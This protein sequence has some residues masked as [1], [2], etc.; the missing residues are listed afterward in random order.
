M[1]FMIQHGYGKGDKLTFVAGEAELGAVI[2]SPTDEDPTSLRATVEGLRS[3]GVRSLLDPQ[4]YLYTSGVDYTGRNHAA[5]GLTFPPIRWSQ[6]VKEVEQ[7][8]SAVVRA[9]DSVGIEDSLIAP[10]F[11]QSSFADMWTALGIQYVRTTLEAAPERSVYASCVFEEIAFGGWGDINRWLDEVTTLDVAGFYL[12]TN[13]RSA[14]AY[15]ATGWSAERLSNAM[16]MIYTLTEI[17]GY[18]LIWGYSDV[19]GLLGV[20]VGATAGATGWHNSLRRFSVDKWKPTSGGSQPI[21][22]RFVASL[23]SPIR[24]EGEYDAIMRKGSWAIDPPLAADAMKMFA[25]RN[26]AAWSRPLAQKHHMISIAELVNGLASLDLTSRLDL[27]QT[28]VSSAID[29]F[30]RLSGALVFDTIYVNKLKVMADAI[31]IFR[32]SEGV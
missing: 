10:S 26:P 28:E 12:L 5:H 9:N 4:T 3:N 21:S 2:L 13:H 27:I 14:G 1:T 11:L 15:P 22:R 16:R 30:E 25:F 19:V 6:G 7:I 29:I 32:S 24:V 8:V 23:L 17:N 20:A 31:E 18:E